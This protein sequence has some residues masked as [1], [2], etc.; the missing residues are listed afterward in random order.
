MSST[1]RSRVRVEPFRGRPAPVADS[2]RD[3]RR[4]FEP[5][6]GDAG[7]VE[8]RADLQ[9][10]SPVRRVPEMPLGASGG[11]W[12]PSGF[13]AGLLRRHVECAEARVALAEYDRRN[14]DAGN[15]DHQGC[16]R[17]G[18]PG[19]AGRRETRSGARFPDARPQAIFP[20]D[21]RDACNQLEV[22]LD[23]LRR[24]LEDEAR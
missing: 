4:P 20:F 16:C 10:R 6:S 8:G 5:H 24:A 13:A 23:R 19:E 12:T 18:M 17:R 15:G 22:L 9:V 3:Q 11:R 7:L 14:P 2:G 1:S 21:T